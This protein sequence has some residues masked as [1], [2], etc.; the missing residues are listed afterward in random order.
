MAERI[1]VYVCKCGPNIGDKVD[2][3]AIVNEVKSIEDV[4][5]AK[6]H[7]LLCSGE[8]LKFLKEEIKNEKLSRVV[9]AACTPK[10]YEVKFMRACEEAGLNPYL[11]QM[12]KQSIKLLSLKLM[13]RLDLLLQII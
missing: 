10:Q 8:G 11:M 2:V 7:N 5:V 13:A 3:D 12:T 9:I 4:A 1:G 6:S